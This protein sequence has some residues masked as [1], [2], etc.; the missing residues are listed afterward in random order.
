[1]TLPANYNY[2]FLEI[3]RNL[4]SYILKKEYIMSIN[5]IRSA[6]YFTAKILGDV[7]AVNKG[8]IGT[9]ILR[10]LAGKFTGRLM[11]KLFR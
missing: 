1:M 11:G 10:R 4:I 5:K 2:I 9:R 3:N 7:N 6:L 8:K